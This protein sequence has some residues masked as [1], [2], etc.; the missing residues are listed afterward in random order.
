VPWGR[1]SAGQAHEHYRQTNYRHND[2][3]GHDPAPAL[4]TFRLADD[5]VMIDEIGSR[6]LLESCVDIGR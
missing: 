1:A 6:L 5:Q 2:G 3:A 4:T